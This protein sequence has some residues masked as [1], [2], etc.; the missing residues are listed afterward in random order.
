[1]PPK[2]VGVLTTE[3]SLRGLL[4]RY[5]LPADGK[6]D[7]MMERY[8]AL[9][10]A[11]E[12]ANDRQERTSYERL[13]QRVATAG[14]QRAAASLLGGNGGGG[15]VPLA[16]RAGTA[17]SGG[18]GGG[19]GGTLAGSSFA[20]LIAATK[21]RDAARRAARA[22]TIGKELDEPPTLQPTQQEEEEEQVVEKAD[23]PRP[24]GP[25][26]AEVGPAATAPAAA[27]PPDPPL[28]QRQEQPHPAVVGASPFVDPGSEGLRPGC[29][30][31]PA[32]PSPQGPIQ[33]V[34]GWAAAERAAEVLA[35]T[36]VMLWEGGDD[37]WG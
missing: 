7:A 1:V 20:E 9:R 32:E 24:Q 4:R 17:G 23:D 34:G 15:G 3:K 2:L 31:A 19:G 11:V 29:A 16:R 30:A 35:A 5:G 27:R 10:L 6:K 21:A 12:T 8:Q 33:G 26:A 36:E 13:A 14:R 37:D 18:G 25:P 22:A 28:E